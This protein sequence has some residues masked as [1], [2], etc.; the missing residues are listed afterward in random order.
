[1]TL[2]D[3]S[4]LDLKRKQYR[5]ILYLAEGEASFEELCQALGVSKTQGY[6]AVS[7]LVRQGLIE[8]E[9]SRYRLSPALEGLFSP[10]RRP[11]EASPSEEKPKR[12]GGKKPKPES[13]V[14]AL[15]QDHPHLKG[16]LH[17]AGQTLPKVA[18]PLAAKAPGVLV[19]AALAARK[20]GRGQEGSVLVSW[21]PDIK[22][23]VEAWGAEAVEGALTEA[24]KKADK[25]FPYARKLL[26]AR[27][28]EAPEVPEEEL[29]YF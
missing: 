11:Q 10:L 27:P 8:K 1:M 16:L 28:E 20:Y 6:E 24:T 14:A 21:L 17:F 29:G 25:P 23:W 26:L 22:A 7:P 5:A 12:A 2:R 18:Q 13:P 3:L 19:G 15:A 4:Q 9:G